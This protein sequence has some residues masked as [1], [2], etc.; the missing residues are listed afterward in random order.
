[1]DVIHGVKEIW[2]QD[3]VNV[4]TNCATTI[5]AILKGD[6]LSTFETALEEARVDPEPDNIEDPTPLEV[7][8]QHI[9]LQC[10]CNF[11]CIGNSETM[12][13]PVLQETVRP[14]KSKDC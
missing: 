6:S 12:D 11:S 3:S 9:D 5:V 1:M 8:Q 7:M 2:K 14:L 4:P 13:D 10:G